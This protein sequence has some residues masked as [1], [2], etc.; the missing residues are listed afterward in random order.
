MDAIIHEYEKNLEKKK[1]AE[2]KPKQYSKIVNK[3]EKR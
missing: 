3:R 2:E 1:K